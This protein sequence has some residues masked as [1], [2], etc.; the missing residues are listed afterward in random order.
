MES[1][2]SGTEK[3]IKIIPGN[4]EDDVTLE[5]NKIKIK[6]LSEWS[7]ASGADLFQN[8][9]TG[10]IFYSTLKSCRKIGKFR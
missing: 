6:S 2:V 10:K 5:L 8:E 1:F 4:E 9:H 7:R 3:P